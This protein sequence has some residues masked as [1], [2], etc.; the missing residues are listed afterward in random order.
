MW[1]QQIAIVPLGGGLSLPLMAGAGR[2]QQQA[3]GQE[4]HVAD[5][6]CSNF[7][8]TLGDITFGANLT[9]DNDGTNNGDRPD[10]LLGG[11]G[12][13]EGVGSKR[14]AGGN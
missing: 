4:T 10:V 7:P 8:A 14:T 9:V 2:G 11:G 1:P 13:G 12:S 6:N 5:C 3:E